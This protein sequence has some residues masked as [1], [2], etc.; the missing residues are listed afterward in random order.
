MRPDPYTPHPYR[1]IITFH[2]FFGLRPLYP[3]PP[4]IEMLHFGWLA[5]M[6]LYWNLA[7]KIVKYGARADAAGGLCLNGLLPQRALASVGSCLS[8][9]LPSVGCVPRRALRRGFTR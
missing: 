3:S 9:L 6:I 7:Y 8:G 2:H 4:P 5:A 1:K